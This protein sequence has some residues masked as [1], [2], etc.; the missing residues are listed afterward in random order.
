MRTL[1]FGLILA[2]LL[3]LADVATLVTGDGDYPP[4]AVA[5]AATVLGVATLI[6]VVFGWRGNRLALAVVLVTRVLSAIGA[7]PGLFVE[8]VPTAVRIVVVAVIALTLI[9]L[10]MILPGLRRS[11]RPA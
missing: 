7:A 11:T 3:G 6:A 4:T 9:S 1:H 10:L 5:I 8:D 2:A